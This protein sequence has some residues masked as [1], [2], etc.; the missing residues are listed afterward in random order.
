[1][2]WKITQVHIFAKCVFVSKLIFKDKPTHVDKNYIGYL[3]VATQNCH[4]FQNEY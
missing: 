2:I 3:T 1:M 4:L